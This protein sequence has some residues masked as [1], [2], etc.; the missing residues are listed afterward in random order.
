MGLIWERKIST[1]F[2]RIAEAQQP[3]QQL[4]AAGQEHQQ[5]GVDQQG[6]GARRLQ[7]RHA[8]THQVVQHDG[9]DQERDDTARRINHRGVRAKQHG[10]DA[11]DHGGVQA[12]QDRRRNVGFAE[13]RECEQAV[14]H[15]DRDGQHRRREAARQIPAQVPQP[16]MP[17]GGDAG[18]RFRARRLRLV[19]EP[20]PPLLL[21]FDYKLPG[22]RN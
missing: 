20:V 14:A 19:R 2:H 8:G 16:G 1:E 22:P 6:V 13:R 12:G 3:E 4:K 10:H 11:A 17:S 5:K 7:C 15:A 21:G 18:C 9:A